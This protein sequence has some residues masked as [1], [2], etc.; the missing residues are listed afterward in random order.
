VI[1]VSRCSVAHGGLNICLSADDFKA[2][3]ILCVFRRLLCIARNFV[4]YGFCA[5]TCAK[6]E[7]REIGSYIRRAG[8]DVPV[9]ID[10]YK[11]LFLP[12]ISP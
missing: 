1:F 2:D 3:Y 6:A 5:M 8:P 11:I 12:P 10:V 7:L 9:R 4:G